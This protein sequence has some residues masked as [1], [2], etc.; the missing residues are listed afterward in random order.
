MPDYPVM[1][2]F[3]RG[4]SALVTMYDLE[5]FAKRFN[6][7]SRLIEI[8]GLSYYSEKN[9]IAAVNDESGII[10]FINPETGEVAPLA[11]IIE[12]LETVG[13]SNGL[14]RGG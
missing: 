6:L 9:L 1:E 7:P 11:V 12:S 4:D 10:F 8:S 5:D 2:S 13:G 3:V 14:Q